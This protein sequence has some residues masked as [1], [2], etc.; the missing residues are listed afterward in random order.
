MNSLIDFI[1]WWSALS[2]V[3]FAIIKTFDLEELSK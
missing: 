3:C 1:V 2:M